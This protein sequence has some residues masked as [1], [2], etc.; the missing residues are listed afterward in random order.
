[1]T[2]LNIE[3][4]IFLLRDA[5]RKLVL[6]KQTK[7]FPKISK[8]VSLDWKMIPINLKQWVFE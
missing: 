1:M 4:N 5:Q 7:S 3:G 2:N 8:S 6:T